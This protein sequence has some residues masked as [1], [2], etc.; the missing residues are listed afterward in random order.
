MQAT[1]ENQQPE[2]KDAEKGEMDKR[3]AKEGQVERKRH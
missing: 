3:G 2:T 1:T